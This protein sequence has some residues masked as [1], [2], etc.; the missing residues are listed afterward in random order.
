MFVAW[1][2]KR[3]STPGLDDWTCKERIRKSA[4]LFG[5]KRKS[6]KTLIHQSSSNEILWVDEGVRSL[7]ALGVSRQ[8]NHLTGTS[9]H[10]PQHPRSCILSW[11]E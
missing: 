5:R 3:L 1:R 7:F 2:E 11:E 9:A 8:T 6:K 4:K 10:A